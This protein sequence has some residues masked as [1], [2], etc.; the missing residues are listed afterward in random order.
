M[1][2]TG[3]CDVYF[4]ERSTV[5]TLLSQA[6]QMILSLLV[7]VGLIKIKFEGLQRE[8]ES[9]KGVTGVQVGPVLLFCMITEVGQ[10]LDTLQL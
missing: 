1:P 10:G 9:C 6:A 8:V 2:S 7:G 5:R 3:K 4:I